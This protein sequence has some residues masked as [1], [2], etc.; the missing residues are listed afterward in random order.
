MMHL[1]GRK[2]TQFGLRIDIE[3]QADDFSDAILRISR[4]QVPYAA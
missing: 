2:L 3:E 4:H 1:T